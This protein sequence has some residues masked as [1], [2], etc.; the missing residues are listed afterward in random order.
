MQSPE[1]TATGT[2]LESMVAYGPR[3]PLCFI[4]KPGM[5]DERTVCEG[6]QYPV[7]SD[8]GLIAMKTF[9]GDTFPGEPYLIVECP[10]EQVVLH[11]DPREKGGEV[12]KSPMRV[13]QETSLVGDSRS[14]T[15]RVLTPGLRNFDTYGSSSRN[16]SVLVADAG[17]P[18]DGRSDA[19][20]QEN[21]KGQGKGG[22]RDSDGDGIPD[23]VDD[24]NDN[25]GIPDDIDPDGGSG[26]SGGSNGGGGFIGGGGSGGSNG[27]STSG[28]S[29]GGGFIGGGGS[30]GGTGGVNGGSTGGTNSG[31]N[32]GGGSIGG[33][34]SG[35]GGSVIGSRERC[36][37]NRS[38]VGS[39][40]ADDEMTLG[41]TGWTFP[42]LI[43]GDCPLT[44]AV[45][46]IN[47]EGSP[48]G[49]T[50]F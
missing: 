36:P 44:A 19:E 50:N 40:F 7:L 10:L 41:Q 6:E 48:F 22:G 2:D 12:T 42:V 17:G 18:R 14:K 4:Y 3:Q 33:G 5:P 29:G 47:D 11:I 28:S 1:S 25:D 35:S 32:G 8:D 15:G 24:D 13:A 20:G 37:R 38:I 39:V 9:D 34:G 31:G 21:G 49:S 43:N 26:S 23:D 27:G 45:L 16:G 46:K 30:G